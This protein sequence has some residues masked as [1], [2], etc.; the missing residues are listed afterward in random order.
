MGVA[1]HYVAILDRLRKAGYEPR[2]KEPAS[3][4][5]TALNRSPHFRQIGYRSGDYAYEPAT[6]QEETG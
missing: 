1:I 5:L 4:L 3:T 6:P 2:G